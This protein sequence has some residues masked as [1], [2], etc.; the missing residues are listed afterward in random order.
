MGE[1]VD[2]G[3]FE[4]GGGGRHGQ[5]GSEVMLSGMGGEVM[6]RGQRAAGL[7]RAW[8]RPAHAGMVSP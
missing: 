7:V 5:A 8:E 4:G 6:A 2:G 3:M 1:P